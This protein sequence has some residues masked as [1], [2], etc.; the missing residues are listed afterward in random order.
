MITHYI[1]LIH[2]LK[3]AK[4]DGPRA[5]YDDQEEEDEMHFPPPRLS[6]KRGSVYCGYRAWLLSRGFADGPE[7]HIY[8]GKRDCWKRN[9]LAEFDGMEAKVCYCY[10]T[11][12]IAFKFIYMCLS[13]ALGK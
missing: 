12:L 2:Q 5:V 8:C 3:V 1:L 7:E 11:F 13:C 10:E 4:F 9:N 6:T